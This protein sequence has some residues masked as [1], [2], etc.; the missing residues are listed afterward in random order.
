MRVDLLRYVA[1][2]WM[3]LI[4]PALASAEAVPL[5]T[6]RQPLF[7]L[8]PSVS[9]PRGSASLFAGRGEASLFAPWPEALAVPLPARLSRAGA[10]AARRIRDLIA[11]AEAGPDGY[12][13]VQWGA[14]IPP[15]QRPTRLTLAQIDQ[16]IRDTPNQPH[17]IGRYQFIPKTLRWL[18]ARLGLPP[19]T[20]FTPG[21][22]DRLANL[23]LADAGLEAAL[24]GEMD[25]RTFMRN[26]ARTWAGFPLPNGQSY[27]EG[28]AGNK[29]TMSWQ[30]FEAR[31][32][33]ILS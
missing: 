5:M 12:D 22:Q 24:S 19:E 10:D 2:L 7:S 26:L 20:R 33:R 17:A 18:V 15:P 31:I 30:K 27:Y 29:A 9:A 23:L 32:A 16:W 4:W 8:A 14:R 11:K 21:I 6:D 25:Q 1:G 28:F 13:A 3:C